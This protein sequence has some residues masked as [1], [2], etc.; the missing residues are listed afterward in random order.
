MSGLEAVRDGWYSCDVVAEVAVAALIAPS[1][2]SGSA[3]HE[4]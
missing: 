2:R 1:P 3:R 4:T